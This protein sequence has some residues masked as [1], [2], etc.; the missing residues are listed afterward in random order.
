MK[1]P[2]P[3]PSERRQVLDEQAPTA[4]ALSGF[5]AMVGATFLSRSALVIVILS[6]LGLAGLCFL[7][8]LGYIAWAILTP[9]EEV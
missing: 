3:T 7:A 6:I 2:R 4:A 1:F 5:I 9:P 8:W